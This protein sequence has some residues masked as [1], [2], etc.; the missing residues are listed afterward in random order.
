MNNRAPSES[1]GILHEFLLTKKKMN[2]WGNLQN[3]CPVNA[4]PHTA[5]TLLPCFT[6]YCNSGKPLAP[7]GVPLSLISNSFPFAYHD[8]IK[9]NIKKV[10]KP[11]D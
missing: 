8:S 6:R 2:D 5:M 9:T 3:I 4:E 7:Q 11:I 10:Q 1:C